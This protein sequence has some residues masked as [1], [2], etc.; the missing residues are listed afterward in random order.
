MMNLT[1]RD[2][3]TL[4]KIC[5]ALSTPLRVD[6]VRI[7]GKRVM[8][9]NELGKELGY[10]LSTISVNVQ[11]LEDAGLVVCERQAARHGTKKLCSN[12]YAEVMLR[13]A[14]N[15][16]AAPV[17][18]HEAEM[19][20]GNYMDFDVSPS[21]GLVMDRADSLL[22]DMPS[23]FLSPERLRAGL[24]WLRKGYVEYRFPLPQ[25]AGEATGISF[26]MELCSEAPGYNMQWKSDI[27]LWINSVEVGTWTCPSDFG[28]RKGLLTP[29][30]W[31][32]DNTQ[33]GL[34]T[35]WTVD[36]EGATLNGAQL[37]GATV[38]Q[39]GLNK[40][41]FV[42]MRIGVKEHAANIGGLNLFGRN[43][44]DY[45]QDIRMTIQYKE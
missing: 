41:D 20:I 9:C 15:E 34:L 12:V 27:T 28:D 26:S 1:S 30:F 21:C 13:L 33:Y 2:S 36:G 38:R 24:L 40:G 22:L 19:P 29:E 16:A 25:F 45:P 43:F 5:H 17:S 8:S 3:Q 35:H 18:R 7:L 14:D 23:V 31:G 32:R 6:I 37:S 4:A 44:G 39:L 10:P 11:I 42:R